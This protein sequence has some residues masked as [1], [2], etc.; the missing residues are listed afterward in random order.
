[1]SPSSFSCR[2][3]TWCG[4]V[5]LLGPV[6]AAPIPSFKELRDQA[7]VHE[8]SAEW[9]KALQIYGSLLR[10]QNTAELQERYQ[11]CLRRYWQGLRHQDLSFSKEVL[12]L[13]YG[14]ALRLY[15][16][17]RDTL[18]D[19]SVHKK[20]L[21]PAQLLKKGIDELDAALANPVF[22]Q[23][24]LQGKQAEAQ[25]FREH[26]KRKF[27]VREPMTR[28]QVEKQIREIALAAQD[29]LQL[30][31]TVALME[32]ACGAAYAVDNYTAYLTP[33]QFREL[34]DALRGEASN[35]MMIRS[36][37]YEWNELKYKSPD[38]GY[39]RILSFQD[40]TLGE[41]DEA[42]T[43]LGKTGVKGLI[44]DLRG[45][46]GG[47]VEVAIDSARRFLS[48]GIIASVENQDPKFTTVYHARE[49]AVCTV[50]LVVLV[51]GDTASAAEV[52]AGA[53]KENE[54][55]R[56]FGQNTFG[57]GCTQSLVKLPA[58]RGIPTG[59]L[60]ITVARFFS[61]KGQPYTPRGVAPDVVVARF[62]Q[63]MADMML[64]QQLAE[65]LADLQRQLASLR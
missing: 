7:R 18:L 55:A 17:I 36:V 38:V 44:L 62:R 29:M 4:A 5:A 12:S 51:D 23:I 9:D 37:V 58:A 40:N 52:F 25:A 35:G 60:R 61:P 64:D 63:D 31:P 10:E 16:K 20:K 43:N 2:L 65:G 22:S 3:L 56:L 26:L 11:H 39:V 53:L 42:L 34:C 49:T 30:N 50:P 27:E 6:S 47:L 8:R 57:K 48:S 28:A 21:E 33:Q 32:L 54:R 59:G 1:M 15:N 41:L 14:Q 13:D 45:N 46:P 19:Q 24:Y